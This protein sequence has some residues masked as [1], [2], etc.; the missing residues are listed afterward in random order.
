MLKF[1]ETGH[2]RGLPTLFWPTG[3]RSDSEI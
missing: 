1:K 2:Q 3:R